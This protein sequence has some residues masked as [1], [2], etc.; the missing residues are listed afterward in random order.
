MSKGLV[1][2]ILQDSCKIY[3]C[4]TFQRRKQQ[5]GSIGFDPFRRGSKEKRESESKEMVKDQEV[6]DYILCLRLA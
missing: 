4:V 6:P 2:L 5:R 3:V 1:I